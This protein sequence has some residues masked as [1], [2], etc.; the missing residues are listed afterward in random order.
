[1]VNYNQVQGFVKQL[2]AYK[3]AFLEDMRQLGRS[4]NTISSYE[5]EINIFIEFSRE[6]DEEMEIEDINRPFIMQALIFRSNYSNRGNISDNTKKLF[7]SALKSYFLFISD[8]MPERK[9]FMSIF[10][11]IVIKRPVRQ[12]EH[13]TDEEVK[14][15]LD[16][17][18]KTKN[19]R[20][21]YPIYRN[22]LLIKLMLFAGLRISEALS[23]KYSNFEEENEQELFI[24]KVIGKG[25]K[26][27]F[28][29]IKKSLIEDDLLTI[30]EFFPDREKIMLTRTGKPLSRH[31]A[32]IMIKGYL[33]K[34][35]IFKTGLH[36]FRHTL[37]YRLADRGVPIEDIQDIL[38][39]SNINTTRIYVSRT[40]KH[41]LDAI[42]KLYEK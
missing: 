10:R 5:R 23:L 11:K 37:G 24:I 25:N 14:R 12:K 1:M 36:I 13:L 20:S 27:E 4:Q 42:N 41:K 30:K 6:F 3:D 8:V 28:V 18:E 17:I 19:K 35:N 33:K 22:S 7:I 38:R 2:E 29:Y 26:E 40:A 16:Y 34:V 32:Y 39:H 21:A 15:L 31:S 9:D